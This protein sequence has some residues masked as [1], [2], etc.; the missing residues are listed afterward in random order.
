M[1]ISKDDWRENI[2]NCLFELGSIKFQK[3][4]WLAEV[5]D[6]VGLYGESIERLGDCAVWEDLEDFYEEGFLSI[7]EKEKIKNLLVEIDKTNQFNEWDNYHSK[8]ELE[9]IWENPLWKRIS[10]I[11]N[12]LLLNHFKENY[13]SQKWDIDYKELN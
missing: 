5:D 11:A 7:I 10:S 6:Y 4:A 2:S 12:D 3:K 1:T 9:R 13:I 8:E